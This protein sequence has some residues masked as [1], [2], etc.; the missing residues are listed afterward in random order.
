MQS[1]TRL[2]QVLG[3]VG[4]LSGL[5]L[6]GLWKILETG[7]VSDRMALTLAA[8]VA[9]T[10]GAHMAM[11]GPLQ[12]KQAGSR[13][14]I[15]GA[16]I[17]LLITMAA[18][19]YDEVGQ[20][21]PMA[22]V[23]CVVLWHIALPFLIC[24]GMGRG[25]RHYPTLYAQAWNLF[26]RLAAAWIFAGLTW[27]VLYMSDLVLGLVGVPLMSMIY[28]IE[29]LPPL[30]TGAALGLGLA[31]MLEI[32]GAV[33]PALLQRLLRLLLPVLLGVVVVFL[34]ILPFRSFDA[35]FGILSAGTI[36]LVLAGLMA[37][38]VTAATGP[39]AGDEVPSRPMHLAAR[40]MAGLMSVPALLAACALWVRVGQYGWTPER[41]AAALLIGITL[42]SAAHYL[43]A[44]LRPTWHAHVRTGNVTVA[45]AG[46]GLAAL[47]VAVLP[48]EWISAR[49]L[50]A[51]Y[52]AGKTPVAKLETY[53]LSSWGR[54][55][56]AA[57]AQ[58]QAKADAGDTALAALLKGEA[59]PEDPTRLTRLRSDLKA[60]LPV[61]PVTATATRDAML[62]LADASLL[63]NW[64][65]MCQPIGTPPKSP[66]GVVVADFLTDATGEE[67]L[68]VQDSDWG[69]SVTGYSFGD[70]GLTAHSV[71]ANGGIGYINA[72]EQKDYFDILMSEP[73]SLMPAPVN[74]IPLA[75]GILFLPVVGP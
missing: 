4:A 7:V 61:Q 46:I 32:G 74:V 47:W 13:S 41:L 43:L 39:D 56:A 72:D 26:E 29:P 9:A 21:Q 73:P 16:L 60:L 50:I 31:V 24:Q 55:G 22:V 68:F 14:L 34:A 1:E 33:V 38:M 19:R 15:L 67:I 66:C 11:S 28:D 3:L 51:R 20:M 37:T 44:A 57:L 64:T 5:A 45:L 62:D 25:F 2:R 27:A 6:W 12:Q 71:A 69:L 59:V 48:V 70:A 49:S 58:L 36:F 35:V 52:E 17:S 10:L 8:F 18:L 75:G 54:P 65:Q 63:E 23:F 40:A 53:V 42:I 30:I